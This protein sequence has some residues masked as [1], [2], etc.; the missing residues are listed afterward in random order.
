MNI[1]VFCGLNESKVRAKLYPLILSNQ[2]DRIYLIRDNKISLPK[3]SSI[4]V[5]QNFKSIPFLKL[6]YKFLLGI[7]FS[8]TKDVKLVL[9]IYLTPHGILSLITGKL[10]NN[11]TILSLIG[12][13]INKVLPNSYILKLLV[14]SYDLVTVTGKQTKSSLF[15]FGISDKKIRIL[16]SVISMNKFYPTK[17]IKKYDLIFIG[18]LTRNKRLDLVLK[19]ISLSQLDINI[20][21]LGEGPLGKDYK[22]LSKELG[23]ASRTHFLGYIDNISDYIN[24]S[25]ALVLA[26]E[27]EGMPQCVMEAMAC[28]LPCILPNINDLRFVAKNNV[29]CLTFKSLDY[30]DLTIKIEKL[31]TDQILYNKLSSNARQSVVNDFSIANGLDIWDSI[32]NDSKMHFS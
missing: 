24:Q 3:V 26:S 30:N 11:K 13:D 5:P 9:G 17:V 25:R 15:N 27:N 8:I 6:I 32:L 22:L 21:I 28:G 12:T 29:N 2:I 10:F 20:V 14:Q 7:Y 1:I 4:Y 18:N 31:I 23:L 19:S 16:P